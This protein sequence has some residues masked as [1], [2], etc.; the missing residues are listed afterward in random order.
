MCRRSQKDLTK[1]SVSHWLPDALWFATILGVSDFD[2]SPTEN[3]MFVCT[4]RKL[5][6]LVLLCV[7]GSSGAA[8]VTV[9]A[10]ANLTFTPSSVTINAGDSVKFV[11]S[12]G[13]FHN[14]IANDN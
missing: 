3:L 5:F 7:A 12:G 11:N 10:N 2:A 4:R 6:A 14:A 1:V 13:G 9:T 8:T